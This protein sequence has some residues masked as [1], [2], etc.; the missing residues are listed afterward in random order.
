MPLPQ[1]YISQMTDVSV[2]DSPLATRNIPNRNLRNAQGQI[3]AR[4]PLTQAAMTLIPVA[5]LTVAMSYFSARSLA[6]IGEH[7]TLQKMTKEQNWKSSL[8]SLE[9]L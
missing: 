6:L 9:A 8:T 3:T 4:T 7:L 2:V 1:R 5:T